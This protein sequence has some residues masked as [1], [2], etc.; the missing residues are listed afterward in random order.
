[1][2]FMAKKPTFDDEGYLDNIDRVSRRLTVLEKEYQKEHSFIKSRNERLKSLN[3]G[4]EKEIVMIKKD[5]ESI[6]ED[7]KKL[8][9]NI[10]FVGRGLQ[11]VAKKDE[12]RRLQERIDK[13]PLELFV[14]R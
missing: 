12:V 6:K 7:L 9:M 4:F 14:K 2:F 1:M 8:G 11:N 3:S 13:W 5:L 10:G